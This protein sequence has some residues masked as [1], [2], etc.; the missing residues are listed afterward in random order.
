MSTPWLTTA[1]AAKYIKV[2]R[3]VLERWA[4]A[5]KVRSARTP[6]GDYRFHT[7]WLDRDLQKGGFDGSI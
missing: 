6:A 5:K 4:R 7:D 2:N 3:R 1:E